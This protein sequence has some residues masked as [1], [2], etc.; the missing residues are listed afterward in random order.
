MTDG[1]P[2][3]S[4][5]MTGLAQEQVDWLYEQLEATVVW[6][7]PTGRPHALSLYT[8]LVVVLFGLRHNM[9]NDVVGEL[10]GCS[11]ST[12]ERYQDE[13]EPLIDMFL[14]PLYEQI[15]VQAHRGAVLVDGFVV[16]V[17]ERDGIEGMFSDK[18]GYCGQNVQVVATLSGRVADVG[19]PCPRVYARQSGVPGVW[20]RRAVGGTLRTR[21]NG[22]DGGQ[23]LSGNRNP[24]PVQEAAGP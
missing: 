22:H 19:D 20:D 16:P 24:Y 21:R 1:R 8:A 18:K 12:V 4:E 11:G 6:D 2:P 17:G 3:R 9:A 7:A 10:F 23:R 14:T 13:L 15:R 5:R